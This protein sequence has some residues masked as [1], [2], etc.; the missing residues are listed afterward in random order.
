MSRFSRLQ[1]SL[2]LVL[3]WEASCHKK[4]VAVPLPPPPVENQ[5][6]PATPE[7]TTTHP[8]VPSPVDTT[9][10]PEPAPYQVNKPPQPA[11]AKK[12]S[13][14]AST[15]APAPAAPAPVPAAP[16]PTPPAPPPKLGDILSPDEQRQYNASIDQSL[17]HAQA[18]LSAIAGRQL[19]KDQQTQAEQIRNFIQQAQT[20]RSSDL[21]GAKSL[22]ERAEILARDL[23]ASFR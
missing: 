22:A 21:G 14:S 15:P 13:R 12:P 18:S 2:V 16:P 23:A 8:E 5:P 17:S 1:A 10:A 11:P 3:V 9:H 7:P 6:A 19:D 20:T 4:Q